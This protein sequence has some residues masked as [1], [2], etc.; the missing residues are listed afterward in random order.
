MGIW[1]MRVVLGGGVLEKVLLILDL[2]RT[3]ISAQG[4]STIDAA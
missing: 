4:I 1:G 2:L 3:F